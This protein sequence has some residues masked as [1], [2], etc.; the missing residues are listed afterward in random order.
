LIIYFLPPFR[1][2]DLVLVLERD[3]D[4]A[5]AIER[6]LDLFPAVVLKGNILDVFDETLFMGSIFETY[7]PSGPSLP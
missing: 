6:D 7:T 5:L 2:L 4:L 1:D 3:R